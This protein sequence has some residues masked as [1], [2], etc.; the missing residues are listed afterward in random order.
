MRTSFFS[1]IISILILAACTPAGGERSTQPSSSEEAATAAAMTLGAVTPGSVTS[2]PNVPETSTN[3]LPHSLYFIGKDNAWVDQVF[4]LER[5]G[6]TKTQLTFEPAGVEEYDVSPVDGSIALIANNQLLLAGSDG[7]NRRVLM[8][9][10][11]KES[12]APVTRPVFSPNGET[13]AYAH[14]GL[15]LYS[16]STGVS[17]LVIEDQYGEPLPEGQ[18]LPIEIYMPE[19]YSPDGT[20]LLLALGHWEV[21]P[22]HA[23]YVPATNELVRYKEGEEY[24]YCCSFHGGPV[25]APDGSSFVGVASAHDYAYL[26][27]ALWKIDAVTGEV[28]TVV[29]IRDSSGLLNLPKEPYLAPDGQLYFFYGNYSDA[30]GYFDAPVQHLVRAQPESGT[31][32]AVLRNENFR[33]MEEALWAPDASFVIVATAPE[34]GWDQDGGVLELYPRDGRKGSIWLAPLG[35][36]MKW[37]P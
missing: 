9:G 33:L 13:I 20:K 11:P 25:W 2:P 5:D 24:I 16:V 32:I 30:Y 7:S 28:T 15:N 10:G 23:V 34:P 22:S 4:R 21:A 29:P 31:G 18:R 12:N 14:N 1:L 8:D 6:R 27:G 17:N 3:L 36:Q 35:E 37:G 19:R 26:S